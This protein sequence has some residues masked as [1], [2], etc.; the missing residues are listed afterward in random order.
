MTK[1]LCTEGKDWNT[2]IMECRSLAANWEQLSGYTD[3]SVL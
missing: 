3:R 2:V 1:S